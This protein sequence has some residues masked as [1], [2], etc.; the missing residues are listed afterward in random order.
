MEKKIVLRREVK[1][2]PGKFQFDS[3]TEGW[4]GKSYYRFRYDEKVFIVHED[5]EFLK[6]WE[7]KKV[8]QIKLGITDE[9]ATM[10]NY[11]THEQLL[12]DA[13]FEQKLESIK[14]FK[15][16]EVSHEDIIG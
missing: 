7:A 15:V 8:Y 3:E 16:E 10:L 5:D 12:E 4:K 14:N 6:D 9:G 2:L 13:V 1:K 11:F